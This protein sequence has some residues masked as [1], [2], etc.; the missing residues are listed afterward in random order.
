M[1]SLP[2]APAPVFFPVLFTFLFDVSLVL[3]PSDSDF[4]NLTLSLYPFGFF[5]I[6]GTFLAFFFFGFL[7]FPSS[8]DDDDVV[9][10]VAS[11]GLMIMGLGALGGLLAAAELLV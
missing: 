8:E 9:V 2:I 1:S 6:V 7:V 11:R 3:P 5:W 4:T 10:V